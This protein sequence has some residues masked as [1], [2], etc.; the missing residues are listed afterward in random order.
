MHHPYAKLLVDAHNNKETNL[1]ENSYIDFDK[2]EGMISWLPAS[3]EQNHKTKE[4]VSE[5]D[6]WTKNRQ[7]VA[8]GKVIRTFLQNKN[9]NFSDKEIEQF[10]NEYKTNQTDTNF[11]LVSGKEI[12]RYYHLDS[13]DLTHYNPDGNNNGRSLYGSCMRHDKCQS[14]FNMYEINEDVA[15]LCLTNDIGKL[16]GRAL[17]WRNVIVE[18]LGSITF[19]DRIYTMDAPLEETFKNYAIKNGW[20]YKVRQGTNQDTHVP[21]REISNGSKNISEPNLMVYIPEHIDYF[22]IRKPYVD[23]FRFF[24][25]KL[26]GEKLVPVLL[27]HRNDR[28]RSPKDFNW[29][30]KYERLDGSAQHNGN[31][32][33]KRDVFNKLLPKKPFIKYENGMYW[34]DIETNENIFSN[35]GYLTESHQSALV[36]YTK[37]ETPLAFVT[38]SY[39]GNSIDRFFLGDKIKNINKKKL[40]K[41]Y[42]EYILDVLIHPSIRISNPSNTLKT[43]KSDVNNFH[44]SDINSV[45]YIDK[46]VIGKPELFKGPLE[47]Y[48]NIQLNSIAK[49]DDSFSDRITISEVF[50]FAKSNILEPVVLAKVANKFGIY[51]QD[52]KLWLKLNKQQLDELILFGLEIGV[53]NVVDNML[54]LP[55]DWDYTTGDFT[56]AKEVKRGDV[57]RL[58]NGS[59]YMS[60]SMGTTGIVTNAGSQI[61]IEWKNGKSNTYNINDIQVQKI[62]TIYEIV[63]NIIKKLKKK[64]VWSNI[65]D[66][67]L[68]GVETKVKLKTS[69]KFYN[70]APEIEGIIT[71]VLNRQSWETE[72][73]PYNVQWSNGEENGYR[74]EDLLA[75]I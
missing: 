48:N 55:V 51:Y 15:M 50:S 25:Y 7:Q 38:V 57:V 75:D 58:R 36:L 1:L 47:F 73:Y 3:K 33:K 11:K 67:D 43:L 6:K 46:L 53:E 41:E 13:Y 54:E 56:N 71:H 17:I 2:S 28:D 21:F 66:K 45:E 23:T 20:W 70:Q 22:K 4:D 39:D 63:R 5:N 35:S 30:E 61:K 34:T 44:I 62:G 26:E 32:N 37:D 52:G 14:Y 68:V 40:S 31:Y 10:V 18:N 8:V 64:A 42:Y 12:A 19:M 74:S 29:V 24:G 27:S 65:S 72:Y 16:I 49:Y 60:Q 9:V 59:Q 69:S